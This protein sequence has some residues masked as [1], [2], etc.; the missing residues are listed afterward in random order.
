MIGA[1]LDTADPRQVAPADDAGARTADLYHWQ[2][3]MAAA[4][5]LTLLARLLNKGWTPS[6][7]D[8]AA[9]ICEHHEDWM[10]D[11]EGDVE[12][13]SAKHREP[14]SGPWTTI[15]SLIGDGGVGHLFGRWLLLGQTTTSRLVSSAAASKTGAEFMRCT[16]LARR[17]AHG[18]ALGDDE[19]ELL[20]TTID[21][22]V[23]VVLLYR[24]GLPPEWCAPDDA[25]IADVVVTP[26]QRAIFL[27]FLSSLVGDLSRPSREV[28]RH[29]AANMYALPLLRALEQP[30]ALA[31]LVWEAVLPLFETRMRARGPGDAFAMPVVAPSVTGWPAPAAAL[32]SRTLELHDLLLAVRTVISNPMAFAPLARPATATKLSMK[33]AQGGCSETSI[34]RAERLRIDYVKY[35]RVR[36]R[37]VPGA[38]AE[39]GTIERALHRVADEEVDAARSDSGRWGNELWHSLSKRLQ[40]EALNLLALDLD[41]DMALGGICELTSR[42]EIWFSPY[43]DVETAI[44][45]HLALRS[46]A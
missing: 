42:C 18:P 31:P 5:G 20:D 2:A 11:V 10:I 21:A 38:R 37:N 4:D 8:G 9:I 30:A 19:N 33:L 29:A 28:V 23:R 35:R 41:G 1:R 36:E 34:A 44:K 27:S 13:V 12:L 26:D 15:A 6:G 39:R 24:K 7:Q 17:R 43:F 32:E 14:A 3:A 40:N 46:G 22:A 25:K 45:S 16:E